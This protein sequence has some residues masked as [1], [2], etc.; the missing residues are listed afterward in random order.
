MSGNGERLE[1]KITKKELEKIMKEIVDELYKKHAAE[2]LDLPI[3][4]YWSDCCWFIKIR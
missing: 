1:T 3:M 4:D 2:C